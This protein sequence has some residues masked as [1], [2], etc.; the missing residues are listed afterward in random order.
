MNNRLE[1]LQQ[2]AENDPNDPFNLYALALECQKCDIPRA[3]TTFNSLIAT[4]PQYVATYYQLGKL[5]QQIGEHSLAIKIFN[6]GIS[7]AFGIGDHKTHRELQ[8][9]LRELEEEL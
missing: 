6:A 8:S 4:H 3:L 7:V 9:A 5:Y 2:F 1:Q